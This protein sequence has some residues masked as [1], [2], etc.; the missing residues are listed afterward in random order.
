MRVC[1]GDF[2]PYT[3]FDH[4]VADIRTRTSSLRMICV[5]FWRVAGM[6][7]MNALN[8]SVRA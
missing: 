2:D 8:A 1:G 5:C 7:S 6:A 4:D 3:L